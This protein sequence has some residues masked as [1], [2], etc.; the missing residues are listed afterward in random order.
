[1]GKKPISQ[2]KTTW[3]TPVKILPS[4]KIQM[5][6]DYLLLQRLSPVVL[7]KNI[8]VNALLRFIANNH[9][10]YHTK[11]TR[12]SGACVQDLFCKDLC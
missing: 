12:L 11:C 1:M 8:Q 6:S 3:I 5:H 9:Y 2:A 10:S 7:Y 4:Q